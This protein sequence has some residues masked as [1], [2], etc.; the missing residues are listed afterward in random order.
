MDDINNLEKIEKYKNLF[1][2]SNKLDRT[3]RL[4]KS[5]FSKL[6]NA[7]N[8]ESAD[9]VRVYINAIKRSSKVTE[10]ML[11]KFKNS[12]K[13][14]K[15]NESIPKKDNYENLL[16]TQG[17]LEKSYTDKENKT[18]ELLKDYLN[19]INETIDELITSKNEKDSFVDRIISLSQEEYKI[20]SKLE[21]NESIEL[22]IEELGEIEKL[23]DADIKYSDNATKIINSFINETEYFIKKMRKINQNMLQNINDLSV[24]IQ[25]N[26]LNKSSKL[27]GMPFNIAFSAGKILEKRASIFALTVSV[28]GVSLCFMDPETA[29]FAKTVSETFHFTATGGEMLQS[30]PALVGISKLIKDHDFLGKIKNKVSYKIIP[31]SKKNMD[32]IQGFYS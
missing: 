24:K 29:D 27:T 6:K 26:I 3:S 20:T 32:L 21:D 17:Y 1:I 19:R 15:I 28:L 16:I 7:F 23:L 31:A 11:K 5:F 22:H 10:N 13:E 9:K 25:Q 18:Y 2:L 4:K 14:T 12:L 8:E 30:L